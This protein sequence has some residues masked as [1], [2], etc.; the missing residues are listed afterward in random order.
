MDLARWQHG[1][2][3]VE[4]QHTTMTVPDPAARRRWPRSFSR[5]VSPWTAAGGCRNR[6][7]TVPSTGAPLGSALATSTRP[8]R[9]R[10]KPPR[11]ARLSMAFISR[12]RPRS[13]CTKLK[14]PAAP[15]VA[16]AQ[17]RYVDWFTVEPRQ[18]AGVGA[19]VAGQDL[20][21]RGL[22]RPVVADEG[23]DLTGAHV[24]VDVVERFGPREG[25]G[26]PRH[27][28]QR[29]L[30]VFDDVRPALRGGAT[31]WCQRS[32]SGRTSTLA[33]NHCADSGVDQRLCE[34]STFPPDC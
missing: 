9:V 7:R 34:C 16:V 17:L 33:L 27:P 32:H 18:C 29:S 19:V 28:Q 13:W 5:P 10:A 20:D 4:H 23:M 31:L 21:Q 24:E 1:G 6:R 12:T 2:R 26:H 30:P 8:K 3:L 14:R 15:C 22:A 11:S 25:L